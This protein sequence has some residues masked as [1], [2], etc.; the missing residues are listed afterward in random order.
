MGFMMTLI[1]KG[2]E[3]GGARP[4]NGHPVSKCRCP[5]PTTTLWTGACRRMKIGEPP[6]WKL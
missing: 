1:P 4:F 5:V 6:V 2:Y 3:P